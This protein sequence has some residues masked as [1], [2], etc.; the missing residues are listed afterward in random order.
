MTYFIFCF[1]HK[2]NFHYKFPT[3]IKNIKKEKESTKMNYISEK[4]TRFIVPKE[5][6]EKLK[7]KRPSKEYLRKK[8]AL[9]KALE[10][11]R[12]KDSE[13]GEFVYNIKF[14]D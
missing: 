4:E 14:L 1:L 11:A 10:K 9:E 3:I 8:E 13:L 12:C 5:D 2:W 7:R 6:L